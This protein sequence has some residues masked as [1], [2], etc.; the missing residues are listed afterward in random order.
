MQSSILR[1]SVDAAEN[2]LTETGK[3]LSNEYSE[4]PFYSE[5]KLLETV[6]S[7]KTIERVDRGTVVAGAATVSALSSAL[8]LSSAFGLPFGFIAGFF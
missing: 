7:K 4:L 1:V 8:S 6:L 5:L 2:V 3:R